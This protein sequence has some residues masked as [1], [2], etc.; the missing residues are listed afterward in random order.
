MANAGDVL[1][2]LIP[3]GGFIIRG[4]E[5]EGIEFVDCKPIS[6]QEFEA[7]FAQVDAWKAEQEA[8]AQAKRSAALAK[9]E[10]LGLDED[11]L[12][13]LGL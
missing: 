2:M 1:K 3:T 8:E 6:K 7:G 4:D 11:D 10:A 12:K 5:Y 9:L 13:A